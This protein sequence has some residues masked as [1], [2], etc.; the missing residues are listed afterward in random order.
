MK[1]ICFSTQETTTIEV[2][3]P[4]TTTDTDVVKADVVNSKAAEEDLSSTPCTVT[5][6]NTDTNYS[7]LTPESANAEVQPVTFKP[8]GVTGEAT[9]KANGISPDYWLMDDIYPEMSD[10]D[11]GE[12]CHANRTLRPTQSPNSSTTLVSPLPR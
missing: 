2:D 12:I 6:S 3:T 9:P 8:E 4:A 1:C 10:V 5:N 11:A 7:Q